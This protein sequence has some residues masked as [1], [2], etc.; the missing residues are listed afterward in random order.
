M[1]QKK[2]SWLPKFE[3]IIIAVFFFSFI[4]WAASRCG[5]VKK[6]VVED[7][8]LEVPADMIDTVETTA[9]VA[10]P[11]DIRTAYLD[12]LERVRRRDTLYA[13]RI[14]TTA[15][16][17]SGP[18]GRLYITI[19]NLKVRKFPGLKEEVIGQ[20]PLYEEVEFMN[21]VTDSTYQIN[22][23]YEIADEPWVKIRTKKGTVGWVYGA[24]VNYYKQ[25]RTGVLE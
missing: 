20:L 1:T 17:N 12:S 16:E 4:I 19:K 7:A 21:E 10:K 23:G 5:G 6:A 14:D 25:K 11:T 22:L 2:T 24:G 13:N 3:I 15:V 9:T 18:Y 8:G